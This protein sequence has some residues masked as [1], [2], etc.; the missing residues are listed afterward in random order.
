MRPF[1]RFVRDLGPNVTETV[2]ETRAAQ[3][4]SVPWTKS[5]EVTIAFS[6]KNQMMLIYFKG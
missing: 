4:E 2:I 5:P 1:L 3:A 6:Q